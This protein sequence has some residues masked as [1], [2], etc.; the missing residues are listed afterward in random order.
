[1]VARGMR[2]R[3]TSVRRVATQLGVTEGAL[4]SRLKRSGPE[5]EDGRCNQ[6]TALD[7]FEDVV[8]GIQERLG[9]GRLTG[10]DRPCQVREIYRV[11]VRD[12]GYAGSYKAVVRHLARRYG[13]P[14]VRALRRVETPAG[15]QAQHDW[16]E[17]RVQTRVA[18]SLRERARERGAEA[19]SGWR[20]FQR[21]V[22]WRIR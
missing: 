11:L 18:A 4:R 17:V 8:H 12:H 20:A 19:S 5:E 14:R 16:F 6:P 7:G 22:C 2:D 10:K 1:M 21:S 15:V 9:D 13:Q 3:G